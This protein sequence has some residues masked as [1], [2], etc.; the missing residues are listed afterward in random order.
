ME[1]KSVISYK[2]DFVFCLAK[3]L[4]DIKNH[5]LNLAQVFSQQP[6]SFKAY[7]QGL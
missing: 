2:K 5:S 4:K 1:L 7:P 6:I 3:T